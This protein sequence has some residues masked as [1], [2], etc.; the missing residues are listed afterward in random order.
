[1]KLRFHIFPLLI[2]AILIIVTPA[3]AY[4]NP[5]VRQ[6]TPP[7]EPE[8][9][10]P[11]AAGPKLIGELINFGTSHDNRNPAVAYSSRTKLK[12]VVFETHQ[13]SKDI[14]GRFLNPQT[15]KKIGSSFYIAST[16]EDESHPD[17]VYDP[18]NNLFLVVWDEYYCTPSI[19]SYCGY[20]IRGRLVH[21][22]HLEGSQFSGDAFTVASQVTNMTT[23]YDLV[24]PSASFNEDD[25]QY[26]V[27][28]QRSTVAGSDIYR[29]IYAQM[30]ENGAATLTYLGPL[31]GFNIWTTGGNLKVSAPDVASA[32]EYST[33]LVTYSVDRGSDVG[34]VASDYLHDTFQ[35]NNGDKQYIGGWW[36]APYNKGD[37]PL[38]GNCTN[39]KVAYDS[40]ENAYNVIFEHQE[41]TSRT[42]ALN[43]PQLSFDTTIHGQFVLP[44][45]NSG[46]FR[47]FV[48]YA[49]P[50]EKS[51]DGVHRTPDLVFNIVK[52][53][54]DI[55]YWSYDFDVNGPDYSYVNQR[56][57][58][59]PKEISARLVLH[60]GDADKNLD[61]PT[62]S[63]GDGGICTAVW[64]E[65][66]FGDGEVDWDVLAQRFGYPDVEGKF[67]RYVPI[68][69]R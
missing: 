62:L 45:Y 33:F 47:R 63:C 68:I 4:N 1:L 61:N 27:V 57:V 17:V 53:H 29:G 42:T 6:T 18:V 21:D 22:Q 7:I 67:K 52:K 51:T 66:Y 23:S 26:M 13:D 39:P 2:L 50:V 5:G 16:D 58:K 24:R 35:G 36:M 10:G 44:E 37:N 19:P 9:S 30:M 8:M 20:I 15:G 3:A 28:F 49:Y 48:D 55:V 65:D 32:S 12:L 54:F 41:S 11:G 60:S 46:T 59:A 56:T 38:T 31:S 69:I 14:K 40:K 34:Y 43:N 64:E 25:K